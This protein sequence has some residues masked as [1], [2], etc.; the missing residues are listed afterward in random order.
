M[1]SYCCA[2][3]RFVW[4]AI[5]VV[6]VCTTSVR[7]DLV[8]MPVRMASMVRS[9]RALSEGILNKMC[10][11]SSPVIADTGMGAYDAQAFGRDS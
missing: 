3:G 11:W 9:E 6:I 2:V 10:H 7:T 4:L 8:M 5:N 1:W